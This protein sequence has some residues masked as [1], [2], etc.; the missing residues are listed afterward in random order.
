MARDLQ[1]LLGYMDLRNFL[2]VV[3]K[4]KIAC[5][6]HGHNAADHF[7][8]VN[9]MVILVRELGTYRKEIRNRQGVPE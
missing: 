4:I 2:L 7:V 8:D 9:K 5:S 6:R 3:D 1:N